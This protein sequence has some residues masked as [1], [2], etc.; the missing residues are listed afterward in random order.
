MP[1]ETVPHFPE[2]PQKAIVYN[3]NYKTSHTAM[4]EEKI[5]KAF[6]ERGVT[7]DATVALKRRNT[8]EFYERI[9]LFAKPCNKESV[10]VMPVPD[11]DY[12]SRDLL[13]N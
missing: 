8:L 6:V 3:W 1:P 7:D 4:S 12:A 5:Y 11:S 10:E 13:N 2:Q 9:K